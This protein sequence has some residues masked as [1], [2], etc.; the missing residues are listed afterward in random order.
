MSKFEINSNLSTP[1]L[2]EGGRKI[3]KRYA[4]LYY[5]SISTTS[6]TRISRFL[7]KVSNINLANEIWLIAFDM[8]GTVEKKSE[9]EISN[10][11]QDLLPGLQLDSQVLVIIS[12]D[13]DWDIITVYE[14]YRVSAL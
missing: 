10:F 9:M 3:Q 1:S 2:L 14:T 5:L 12:N 4:A 6:P 13:I 11:I 8:H 7:Q